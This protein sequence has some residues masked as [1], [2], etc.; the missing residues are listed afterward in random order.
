[1]KTLALV[2]ILIGLS[3]SARAQIPVTDVASIMNS[4]FAHFEDIAKWV[5]SIE[6][7]KTQIDQMKQQ[8]SIQGDLRKWTGNPA[9]AAKKVALDKLGVSD[10]VRE[11]GQARATIV[12]TASSLASLGNTANGTFRAIENTDLDGGTLV[13]DELIHRRYSVLEAQQQ[14]YQQVVTDT[15]ARELELQQDLADTLADLKDAD[16]DAEVRKQTA[17]IEAINGQLATISAA[18]RDQA[19]QVMAQ[20]IANDARLEQERLAAAELEAKN[21]NIANQ[22]VTTFM[23]TLKVRQNSP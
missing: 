23:R 3:I 16:T 8:V 15:K 2:L 21:E 1:M 7:L 22:R 6:Q 10:L 20:K 5:E 11:Y 12:A 17:K 4:Q 18:R 14:N 13:R 19:D 9:D